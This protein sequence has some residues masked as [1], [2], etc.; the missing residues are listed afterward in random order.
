MPIYYNYERRQTEV[1]YT[2]DP[3]VATF[4]ISE[5]DGSKVIGKALEGEI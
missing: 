2:D 5:A 3:T 4:S 1:S